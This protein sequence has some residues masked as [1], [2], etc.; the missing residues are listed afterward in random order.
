[1]VR[2]FSR[3]FLGVL[4]L[5]MVAMGTGSAVAGGGSEDTTPAEVAL[6]QVQ[7]LVRVWGFENKPGQVQKFV[8]YDPKISGANDLDVLESGRGYWIGVKYA[9][10]VELG[11]HVYN[12]SKGWNLFGWCG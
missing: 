4:F 7:G 12:L 3:G 5:A 1:M 10:T 9:Q 6:A 8:L 11:G 2:L